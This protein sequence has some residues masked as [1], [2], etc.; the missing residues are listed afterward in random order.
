L[1]KYLADFA[2]PPTTVSLEHR[3]TSWPAVLT[4]TNDDIAN[5]LYA[6]REEKEK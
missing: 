4:Y 6:R 5:A 3:P 1:Q 2:G